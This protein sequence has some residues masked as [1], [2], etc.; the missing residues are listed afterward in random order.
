[1]KKYYQ[2]VFDV[3]D[4]CYWICKEDALGAL[5]G[6]MDTCIWADGEPADPAMYDN[7]METYS[8]ALSFRENVLAFLEMYQTR[9]GFD[10][11]ETRALIADMDI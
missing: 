8:S 7:L 10:L 5:L 11:T 9:F 1:M 3:L 4:R 6:A 2:A